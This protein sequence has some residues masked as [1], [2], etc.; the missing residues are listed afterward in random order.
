MS[1]QRLMILQ[2]SKTLN[3]DC[4]ENFEIVFV[5]TIE[6]MKFVK[7]DKCFKNQNPFVDCVM[8]KNQFREFCINC[9]YSNE[10]RKCNFKFYQNL[11]IPNFEFE[12]LL[13]MLKNSKK[14]N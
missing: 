5:F 10:K 11:L 7:C 4:I 12:N 2:N 3:F 9:H 14:R 1:I 6:K 8:M 13:T